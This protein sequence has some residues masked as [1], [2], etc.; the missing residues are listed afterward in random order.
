MKHEDDNYDDNQGRRLGQVLP[1]RPAA[2]LNSSLTPPRSSELISLDKCSLLVMRGLETQM[3]Y[4]VWRENGRAL[5]PGE[6]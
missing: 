3:S 1:V 2:C 5:C 6:L 4:L